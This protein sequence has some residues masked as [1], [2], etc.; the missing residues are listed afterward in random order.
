A[1][2]PGAVKA[3]MPGS[4]SPMLASLATHPPGGAGWLYEVKWDGAR[5]LCFIE[6]N[7]LKILSR[8]GKRSEQQYPELSV[9]PRQVKASQAIL[10]GEIAVL[11]DKGRSSFNLIQPRISVSDANA[12][13][14]LSRSA[15]VNLF[16]FDLL[17]LDGYDLRGV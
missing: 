9:L 5:A 14:H 17:Y 3:P 8:S 15:P 2:P 12:V 7:E 11:D 16:L 10:D 4:I 6:N 13:A 1:M